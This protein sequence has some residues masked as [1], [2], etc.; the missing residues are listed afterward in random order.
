MYRSDPRIIL[1]FAIAGTL[2]LLFLP[3]LC[4]CSIRAANTANPPAINGKQEDPVTDEL[5]QLIFSYVEDL[6]ETQEGETDYGSIVEI[7]ESLAVHPLNLNSASADELRQLFML[8][9][10]QISQL[11][12]HIDSHGNLISI[13]ELQAIEG[14]TPSDIR[15]IEPF[16]TVSDDL[17]RRHFTRSNIMD[18]GQNVLFLRYQQLLEQQKGFSD[19]TPEELLANPNA[20]Y[21]GSPLRLY[22]RYRFTWYQNISL[23]ITAEKDPGEEFF[24]GSQPKGFD[25]YSG[26][27]FL[28]DMGRIKVL[29]LGDFQAQFGQGLTFWSGMGFGKSTE[30]IGVKKNGLG[31]R[32]YTSVDENNFLRGAG[33]TIQVGPVEVTGFY[34]SKYRDASVAQSDSLTGEPLTITSLRQSGLHRT[35]GELAGKNAV[36]ERI[37]GGNITFRRKRLKVG[38]TGYMFRLG[39]EYQ[40]NLTFYNQ[41]DFSSNHYHGAGLDYSYLHRNMHFFGETA[42]GGNGKMALING[43][44]ISLHRQF[45]LALIHRHYDPAYQSP[46][47]AAFGENSRTTNEKGLYLGVKMQL[48]PRLTVYGY[49]DHFSFPWMRFRTYMP[50]H[51]SDYQLNLD[52]EPSDETRVS[53]R[54]RRKNKPLNN[55]ENSIN[56]AKSAHVRFLEKVCRSQYRMNLSYHISPSINV[57]GRMEFMTHR[58]GDQ[59]ESGF[60][61]YQDI[62]YRNARHPLAL[63]FRFALFDTEGFDSRIYAYEHDVLYAFSFPFYSDQ[64]MRTY[65]VARWRLL[66]NVDLYARLSRTMYINRTHS[67][68]GLDR[69]EGPTRT[70]VKA[71]VRLRF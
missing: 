61:L 32:P 1:S 23:G 13:Y 7:L 40:R 36:Q 43:M 56:P 63:T 46:F 71:Q 6:L 29:S 30:G 70:E 65:M 8:S 27:F 11:M 67:G 2:A 47:A 69:I 44:M 53:F 21:P 39:A 62:L 49:A 17:P 45:S 19:I 68:S 25:F 9:E 3:I 16:V 60:L 20:R 41:F 12:Q 59:K 57:R 38:L 54:F 33:I 34:S 50:S 35:P 22:A 31:L 37:G 18:E 24:T 42:F 14:F 4:G 28:R 48:S 26:H 66:R 55:I 52:F 5:Q 10:W 64:G 15:A 58:H 51:G